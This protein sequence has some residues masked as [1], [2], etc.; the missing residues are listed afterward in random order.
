MKNKNALS[1]LN[2]FLS[3]GASFFPE[4]FPD[5][6]LFAHHYFRCLGLMCDDYKMMSLVL[7]FP[8]LSYLVYDASF[9]CKNSCTQS[10]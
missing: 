4:L 6:L 8:F 9:I 3:L 2:L 1:F 5:V 10:Q 7:L